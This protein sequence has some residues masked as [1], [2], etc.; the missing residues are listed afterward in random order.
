M[1]P[2]FLVMSGYP[3]TLALP[4]KGGGG[5][6]DAADGLSGPLPLCGGGLGRGEA[7]DCP[8]NRWDTWSG[9]GS[10]LQLAIKLTAIA[11]LRYL[12]IDDPATGDSGPMIVSD[13]DDDEWDDN[14]DDE[15]DDTDPCPSCGVAVYDD[16]EVCPYCGRFLSREDA[17][18]R[19]P[20]WVVAGVVACLAM[21][22]WW[23]LHP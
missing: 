18:R 4:R 12:S 9:H 17:P 19:Q 20:W 22:T 13:R 2:R 10:R 15:G 16:A 21:V 5:Q 8:R 3:P 1:Y 7:T 6:R 23:I 11:R 14:D